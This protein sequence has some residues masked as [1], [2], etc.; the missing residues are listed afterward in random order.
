MTPTPF[1]TNAFVGIGS[2]L[3]DPARQVRSAIAAID[4]SNE[5]Q[6]LSESSLYSSPPMGPPDQPDYVNAVVEIGTLLDCLE[7]LDCLQH[8][9]RVHDRVRGDLRWA[10]RTLDLDILLF[11]DQSIECE[12]LR[13]PHPGMIERA[14]VIIPLAEIAPELMLPNGVTAAALAHVMPP[15]DCARLPDSS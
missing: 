11:G 4:T 1:Y 7:L 13:I 10:A 15:A 5:L 14:F 3:N 2:N 12:R 8:I 6:L 9:E